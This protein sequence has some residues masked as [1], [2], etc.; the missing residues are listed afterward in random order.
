MNKIRDGLKRE[1]K[2]IIIGSIITIIAV[3]YYDGSYV[4]SL[5]YYSGNSG[6]DILLSGINSDIT[7]LISALLIIIAGVMIAYINKSKYK[8][9]IIVALISAV[10]GIYLSTYLILA[11]LIFSRHQNDPL[12]IFNIIIGP[13]YLVVLYFIPVG[14][15]CIFGV[16]IGTSIKKLKNKYKS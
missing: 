16:F 13:I 7:L 10:I 14:L 6:I 15:L 3:A 1:F 8:T 9:G 2:S 5:Y 12:T 11:L 4:Y